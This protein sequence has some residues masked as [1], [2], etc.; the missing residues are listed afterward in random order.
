MV[1]RECIV[2]GAAVVAASEVCGARVTVGGGRAVSVSA[3]GL[4]G[5]PRR[6]PPAQLATPALPAPRTNLYCFTSERV[7]VPA[8]ILTRI[9]VTLCMF[10]ADFSCF[11][12]CFAIANFVKN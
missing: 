8:R 3:T 2:G 9:Q 11:N 1:G 4:G 10:N 6:L 12:C 7:I 5:S